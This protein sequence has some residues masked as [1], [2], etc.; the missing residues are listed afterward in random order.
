MVGCA[1]V[2]PSSLTNN[3]CIFKIHNIYEVSIVSVDIHC[4]LRLLFCDN[5]L[6]DKFILQIM[7]QMR[8]N[9]EYSVKLFCYVDF[10]EYS[11]TL[12]LNTLN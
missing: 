6:C 1:K 12:Y 2:I 10:M 8:D 3:F 4:Y 9:I 7:V 11:D 5:I